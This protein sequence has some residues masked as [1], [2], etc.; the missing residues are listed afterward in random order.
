MI[1]SKRAYGTRVSNPKFCET[2]LGVKVLRKLLHEPEHVRVV[3]RLLAVVL[4]DL[5]VLVFVGLF[6]V[7]DVQSCERENVDRA[8]VGGSAEPL[9][10]DVDRDAVDLGFVR[11]SSELFDGVAGRRVE[12][13]DDGAFVAG[14]CKQR[15]FEVD[16]NAGYC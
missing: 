11:T 5:A 15:A 2:P 3:L 13:P 10:V 4:L 12:Q 16:C 9:R 6:E 1:F 14:S 8:F 7:L